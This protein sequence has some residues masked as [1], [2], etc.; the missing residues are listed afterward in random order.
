MNRQTPVYNLLSAR[1]PSWGTLHDAPIAL[2]FVEMDTEREALKTLA[3]C[4]VS[5]FRTIGVKGPG[6]GAF[7]RVQNVDPPPLDETYATRPLDDGLVVRLGTDEFFLESGIESQTYDHIAHALTRNA[8]TMPG[9][10]PIVREDAS[11][12]I[13]GKR[14]R[15]V[16]AQTCG[17]NFRNEPPGKVVLTRVAGVNVMILTSGDASPRYRVWLDPS[18]ATYLWQQLDDIVH[19]LNGKV[20]GAACVYPQLA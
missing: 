3:F 2:R 20:V 15:E 12:I 7:L 6:A 5:A 16:L 1:N 18:Y 13:A 8:N 19:D 9:V 14:A 11:F 4:D 17:V 10:Y